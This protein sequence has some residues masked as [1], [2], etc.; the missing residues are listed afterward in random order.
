[1]HAE[2]EKKKSEPAPAAKEVPKKEE[3]VEKPKKIIIIPKPVQQVAESVSTI[4]TTRKTISKPLES[5][6]ESKE[7]ELIRQ[8]SFSKKQS[9]KLTAADI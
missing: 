2:E 5:L 8:P 7:L 1:M 3:L 4:D 9:T 6:E